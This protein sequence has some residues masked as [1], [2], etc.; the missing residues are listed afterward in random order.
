[1]PD[2][3]HVVLNLNEERAF[4][5]LS[6]GALWGMQSSIRVFVDFD[7]TIAVE[8]VT[9]VILDRFADPSWREIEGEWLAGTI[10]SR[11]C[12]ARQVDLI[13]ARPSAIDALVRDVEFD[14]YFPAFVALCHRN[15]IPVT[16]ISDGLDRAANAMLARAGL[17]L[18]VLANRFEWLGRDRWRITFPHA[19]DDCRSLSGHCKCATMAD[20]G[21]TL[22]VMIGDGRSDICAADS[23]DL[24]IAKD[25]LAEHRRAHGLAFERFDDFAG[26]IAIFQSWIGAGWRREKIARVPREPVHEQSY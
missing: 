16:V 7:G 3:G 18:P 5:M 26:A 24:V 20:A 21:P 6:R 10:G 2:G 12:M 22:N 9:D 11:E 4:S 23:A 1:V 17:D 15:G 25:A 8:D 13:R 14:R 19:R